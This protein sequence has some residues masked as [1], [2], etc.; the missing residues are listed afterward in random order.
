MMLTDTD[1]AD[2]RAWLDK[3]TTRRAAAIAAALDHDRAVWREQL[4]AMDDAVLVE[5][6]RR[7]GWWIISPG[8]L[9]EPVECATGEWPPLE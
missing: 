7:R 1:R 4:A 3:E 9:G 2:I 6:V 8:P 5:E